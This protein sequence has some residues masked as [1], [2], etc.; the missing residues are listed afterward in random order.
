M[1][2]NIRTSKYERVKNVKEQQR[3]PLAEALLE[4][5]HKKQLSFHVPGHK[6]GSWYKRIAD[7]ETSN[8]AWKALLYKMSE[9]LSIDTTEVAGTD[10]LHHPTGAIAEAQQLAASFFGAEETHFLV[11][12]ST[13]G[14]IALI[15]SC[16][17]EPNNIVLVQRNVHQSVLHGLMLAGAKAVFI[18]PEIDQT[19]GLATAV[20]Y[21]ALKQ[22]IVAYPQAKA[23]FITNPNY[24]GMGV[25]VQ[26]FVKLAHEH[27]IPLLVDEAHGPHY[28]LHPQ[29]PES[30]LKVGADGVVQSTHKMLAGMTMSAMLHLQGKYVD[31]LKVKKMLTILQSS[32]P[33]YPLMASLDI[34]RRYIAIQGASI[35]AEG[36]KAVYEVK[37]AITK[38]PSFAIISEPNGR[39]TAAY[40]SLDPF[41]VAIYC[42]QGQW[43]GHTLLQ[44]LEQAHCVAEMADMKYVL[45]TFS[46]GT[47]L[48]AAQHLITALKQIDRQ[49]QAER[50]SE[51]LPSV[52]MDTNRHIVNYKHPLYSQPVAFSIYG[53]EHIQSSKRVPIAEAIGQRSAETIVPYPPG[54]P[55]LYSGEVITES[56]VYELKQ[57]I[58]RG[59]NV[60]GAE[61]NSL[62]TLCVI[63]TESS[64]RNEDVME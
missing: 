44:K 42:K 25:N 8:P 32:S 40:E 20:C 54:I 56:I 48:Q 11:G 19:T 2:I 46:L 47:T 43:N 52:T 59:I 60:Y 39:F 29:F 1:K 15:L 28:S 33:S 17:K 27:H 13:V 10:H 21:Q 63:T 31:R 49:I 9:L 61:D 12:G 3:A 22:A 24:Y 14:N 30:A 35:F 37:K 64:H 55:L 53:Q 16:C 18:S 26:P 45:L 34:S 50:L 57:L 41:K 62:C 58:Q 38:L 6:D 4:Y 23:I 5:V 7:T 51:P 36:L